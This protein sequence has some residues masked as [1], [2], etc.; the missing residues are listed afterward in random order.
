MPTLPWLNA[1][2]RGIVSITAILAAQ[3]AAGTA[4]VPALQL[5]RQCLNSLCATPVSASKVM[6]PTAPSSEPGEEFFD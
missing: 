5:L 6:M 4:G 1:S 3:L 2:H